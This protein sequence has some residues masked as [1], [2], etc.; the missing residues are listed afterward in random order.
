MY[1]WRIL[2]RWE[3]LKKYCVVYNS[4]LNLQNCQKKSHIT[5]EKIDYK[6]IFF[7]KVEEFES[8][9]VSNLH[10]KKKQRL[11]WVNG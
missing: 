10:C 3:H 5:D 7:K 6:T 1:F 2:M 8:L 9:F 4:K 11:E